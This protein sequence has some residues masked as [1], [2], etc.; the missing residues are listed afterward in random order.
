MQ[1]P[2]TSAASKLTVICSTAT[3][4]YCGKFPVGRSRK[5]GKVK[6]DLSLSCRI[7]TQGVAP[8]P[9]GSNS[10]G[11]EFDYLSNDTFHMK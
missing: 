6:S 11:Q 10:K 4:E 1:L 2:S 8:W 3:S 7:A 5:F 9:E